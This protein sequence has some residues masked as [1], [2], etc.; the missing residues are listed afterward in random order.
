[1]HAQ[2]VRIISGSDAGIGP[3]KPHDVLPHGIALFGSIGWSNAEALV[4]ATTALAATACG[5]DDRK[6]RLLP[7]FDADLLAVRG[8][9]VEHKKQE[10][11]AHGRHE[12]ADFG[13]TRLGVL[14]HTRMAE[15]GKHNK[16][17]C[18]DRSVKRLGVGERRAGIGRTV[19]DEGRHVNGGQHGPK[20]GLRSDVACRSND[21]WADV[22][23]HHRHQHGRTIGRNA[24]RE[25][26]GLLD[27]A[28][29]AA[30]DGDYRRAAEL[31]EQAQQLDPT[32]REQLDE[33][34]TSFREQAASP[35]VDAERAAAPAAPA[36][37]TEPRAR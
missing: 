36:E 2:G 3:R 25:Q 16:L 35:A 11:S 17:G 10:P 27:H 23:T 12:P 15:P 14:Y 8:N 19:Q 32:R 31:V 9:P 34:L 20:V 33:L 26:A 30:R 37:P 28:H 18:R 24:F 1:M 21:R 6:G 5:R 29:D 7:G 22:L 13:C 4:A